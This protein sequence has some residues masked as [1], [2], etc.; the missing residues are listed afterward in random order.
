MK[1]HALYLCCPRCSNKATILDVSSSADGAILIEMICIYC[2]I[3]LNYNTT[4]A[5]L[6]ARATTA[7]I[8][9]EQAKNKPIKPPVLSTV[10]D[11]KWLKEMGIGGE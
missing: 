7:D 9:E 6:V 2:G 8:E 3:F 5:K 11:K 1:W 4:G 10:G